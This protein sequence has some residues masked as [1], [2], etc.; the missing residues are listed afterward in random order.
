MH[1]LPSDQIQTEDHV[2][3]PFS[4]AMAL[5]ILL[6]M[7]L[8][9][10]LIGSGINLLWGNVQGLDF[11][12]VFYSIVEDN[13]LAHRNFIRFSLM[14]NHLTMFVLP[15]ICFGR[16]M[17]R[18]RWKH[19]YGLLRWPSMALTGI[20][21]LFVLGALPLVEFSFW[22][23]QQIPLPSWATTME[24][25][26]GGMLKGIL[27]TESPLELFINLLIIGLIPGIGEELIFR[28]ILQQHLAKVSKSMTVG[29]WT[30]A[31]LFSAMHLQFEGFIPRM[32]LG[33]L[34]SY[35]FYWTANLW[36]P[37]IAHNVYNGMQ[38]F[39]Q[40]LYAEEI[41]SFDLDQATEVSW[42]LSLFSLIFVGALAYYLRKSGREIRT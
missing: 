40:Y 15:G 42:P 33:L 35:L 38:V 6:L 21:L 2:S 20:S 37:I 17:Y 27:V 31:F 34:L 26:T 16:L 5:F 29:I 36:L 24:D 25:N 28:G 14:I 23:N 19:F 32:M 9:F 4:S 12:D 13:T 3:L 1:P 39:V 11:H 10:S 7:I 41:S 22:L 30:S 8:L 18:Q